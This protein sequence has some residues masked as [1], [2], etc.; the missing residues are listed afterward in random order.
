MPGMPQ[1]EIRAV[2][3]RSIRPRPAHRYATGRPTS[4]SPESGQMD[5]DIFCVNQP[6]A[7]SGWNTLDVRP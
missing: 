4:T 7:Q 6:W 3:G 1:G 5:E 2:L